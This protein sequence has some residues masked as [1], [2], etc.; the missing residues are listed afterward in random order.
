MQAM[1]LS[2]ELLENLESPWDWG[3]FYTGFGSGIA[4]VALGF[5]AFT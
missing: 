5:A 1:D 4:L 3:H 2:V